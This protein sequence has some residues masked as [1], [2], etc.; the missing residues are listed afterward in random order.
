MIVF[1]LFLIFGQILG[2]LI[3]FVLI[4][5]S[6]YSLMIGKYPRELSFTL[7]GEGAA[8]LFRGRY[9]WNSTLIGKMYF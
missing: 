5:K 2:V 3:K 9:F 4:E 7:S 6:V 1:S 8:L